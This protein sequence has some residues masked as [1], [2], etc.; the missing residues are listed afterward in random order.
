M[1]QAAVGLL[2]DTPVPRPP[3]DMAH[4]GTRELIFTVLCAA[5]LVV[6]AFWALKIWLRNADPLLLICMIGGATSAM[7]EPLLDINGG[8]W[9]PT[10][11][12]EVFNLAHVN[13]PL[14]VPFVYPWLLG[15]QGYLAYRAF[16]RRAPATEMWKLLAAFAAVDLLLEIPGLQL[17]VYAYYG[18]QPLKLLGLPIWYIPMNAGGPM[19]AG[20]VFYLLRPHFQGL[21]TL[22]L[23]PIFPMSFAL[24][25]F[26]CGFPMWLSLQ[27]DWPI[28]TATVATVACFAL[29]YLMITIFLVATNTPGVGPSRVP[30]DAPVRAEDVAA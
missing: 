10:G 16:V 23:L 8:V 15:G 3:V 14:L 2:F 27:S 22:A 1:L 4:D 7:V 6:G 19:I 24:M 9:W 21:R 11:S 28:G 29:A 30:V 17:D 20:A 26:G 5:P 12:W 25:Y 13:I 18:N